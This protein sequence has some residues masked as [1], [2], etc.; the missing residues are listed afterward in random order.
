MPLKSIDNKLNQQQQ[1]MQLLQGVNSVFS[2]L[3]PTYS[4]FSSQSF[5]HDLA[6]DKLAVSSSG[7]LIESGACQ[8]PLTRIVSDFATQADSEKFSSKP[9]SSR[10]LKIFENITTKDEENTIYESEKQ[11]KK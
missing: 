1:Q 11:T 8:P 2:S 3:G 4:A 7:D 6:W 9:A 10:R 5:V